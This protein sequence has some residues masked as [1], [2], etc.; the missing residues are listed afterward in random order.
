MTNNPT[1]DGVSRELLERV[2]E[3][4]GVRDDSP[5]FMDGIKELRALLDADHTGDS[6]AMVAPAVERQDPIS[7]LSREIRVLERLNESIDARQ[8][9]IDALNAQP[10][11]AA[12]QSTIAQLQARITQLE[13]EAAYAAAGHQAARDRIV[14]L[15]SGRGEPVAY[16]CRAMTT[17]E[18]SK[19]RDWVDCSKEIYDEFRCNPEPN[20][21][22]VMREVRALYTSPPAPVAVVMPDPVGEVVE[23]G[24][25]LKEVSWAKGKLPG[26]GSKLY[27]SA[28]ALL[29]PG[30]RTA[31]D[32]QS[33]NAQYD[34]ADALADTWNACLDTT[35]ALNTPKAAEWHD[36]AGDDEGLAQ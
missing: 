3:S 36:V 20:S 21:H 25:G 27:T 13:S 16:Q 1:I 8:Q 22:G 34:C 14:E 5:Y 33:K 32:F 29:L 17:V 31:D 6:S 12:L 28:P 4:A 30:R 10:E 19:W 24:K 2:I 11:V 7:V 23:F 35:A 18:G 15:E 26:L 9:R